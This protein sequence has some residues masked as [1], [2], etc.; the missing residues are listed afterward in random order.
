MSVLDI[1]R[2]LAPVRTGGFADLA[3]A[4][5]WLVGLL[6]AFAHPAGLV[7]AGV[8]LGVTATS[9]ARA[10]ASGASFGIV[11]TAAGWL[12]A[13]LGGNAPLLAYVPVAMAVVTAL[14]VPPIVASVIRA[15]G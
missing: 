5:A 6:A 9:P 12:W 10:F 13:L 3:T 15:I 1:D 8:A 14:L 2:R 11:V 4:L 7:V